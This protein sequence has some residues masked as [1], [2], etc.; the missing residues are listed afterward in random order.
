[1]TNPVGP[2]AP[3]PHLPPIRI[4][5]LGG[6]EIEV[7]GVP[8]HFGRSPPRKP[9]ALLQSLLALSGRTMSAHTACETL[10]PDADGFDAYRTLVT[11]V[12]RLRRLL[13]HHQAVQFCGKVVSLNASLVWVD[14]WHFEQELS[15]S[16]PLPQQ[17]A[18][19]ELY[20]GPFLSD[21]EHPHAFVPRERLQRRFER[22][23]RSVAQRYMAANDAASA[24]ALYE[25]ALD[26]GATS[27]DIYRE[28]MQCL[29]HTGEC[30]AATQVFQSCRA[31]L[32]RRF[33]VSPSAATVMT[34]RSIAMVTRDQRVTEVA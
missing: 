16:H 3:A 4:H 23:V 2:L 25:R 5:A 30:G 17:A 21:V 29:I 8:L 15:E 11:T 7:D 31:A 6:L 27:E 18:A 34:F 24:I 32:A 9:L 13:Q 14:A 33:G 22:A 10:W 19:L 26:V 1:M 12:Y 20:R 28:L